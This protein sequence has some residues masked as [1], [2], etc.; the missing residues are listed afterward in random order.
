MSVGEELFDSTLNKLG[1][2]VNKT[3]KVPSFRNDI[4]SNNDIAEELARVIGYDKIPQKKFVISHQEK[5]KEISKEEVLES[6]LVRNGF[7]EVINQPFSFSTPEGCIQV[8]NPLDSN[9]KSLRTSLLE[10][11]LI[12]LDYNL[13]RQK[14]SI[15]LFEF[16]NIYEKTS[17]KIVEKRMLG[18]IVAG[19]EG[20]NFKEF[21]KKIDKPCILKIF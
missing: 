8:S 13:R 7:S 10:S 15:K 14:E 6:F 12:N 5:E 17:S 2:S 21:N 20:K 19:R 3:I 1:F 18:I 9:K 16:S 4:V 11:L